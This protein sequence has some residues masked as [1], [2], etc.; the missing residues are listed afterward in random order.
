MSL[1]RLAYEYEIFTELVIPTQLAPFQTPM[2]AILLSARRT[3]RLLVAEEGTLSLGWGA[4]ILAQ[5]AEILGPNLK[6]SRRIAAQDTPIPA[7]DVLERS[8]LPDV[9]DI[10][11]MAQE[12]VR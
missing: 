4:E 11:G 7:S 12:L 8:A 9:G 5:V 6:N 2:Q 10:V 3:Q 1:V